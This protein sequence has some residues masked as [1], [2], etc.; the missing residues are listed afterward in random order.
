MSSAVDSLPALDAP[1]PTRPPFWFKRV[2][3]RNYK[4]I[5]FCDV[6]LEPLTLFV[7]R[8]GAG[9][10][11]FLDALG[12][13]SDFVVY[14][15]SEAI[16][17]HGG[18]DGVRRRGAEEL[19]IE[20]DFDLGETA[21]ELCRG[22]YGLTAGGGRRL[23]IEREWCRLS[24]PGGQGLRG[25]DAD[26]KAVE[27]VG[28]G[29]D[30]DTVTRNEA[31]SPAIGIGLGHLEG[32]EFLLVA[33]CLHSTRTFN[34]NPEGMRPP[35]RQNN[36]FALSRDGANLAAMIGEMQVGR[37]FPFNW[38]PL[39]RIKQYLEVIVPQI[40]DF[41][42][43][44]AGG[45]SILEF[46]VAGVSGKLPAASMSDGTLRVLATLVAALQHGPYVESSA[47]GFEE[48]ESALHPAAAH[49]LIAALDEA[50]QRRQILIT[51]HSPALL[52]AEEVTPD[53]VRVVEYI[54]GQTMIGPVDEGYVE[55]IRRHLSTLGE[56][57]RDGRLGIDVLDLKRQRDLA[58][59]GPGR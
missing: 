18:P 7:G 10:S 16:D 34:F 24:G 40:E 42:A 6:A 49:A 31:D 47:V 13:L 4:S 23:S 38:A 39:P 32:Q 36:G 22:T 50:S 8:N 37:S 26:A 20:I 11:N 48:P 2:R 28:G 12:F 51:T 25:Y 46:T 43:V 35:Q 30:G 29:R 55:I 54:D 59:E 44:A 53:R 3:I 58:A 5:A 33:R 15:L 21:D 57:E 9:K 1:P 52:D 14:G 17:Q 27:L 41:N 45:Y 19:E 56:L